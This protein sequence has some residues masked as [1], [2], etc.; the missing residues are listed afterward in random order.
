MGITRFLQDK[1]SHF[2]R[3]AKKKESIRQ[4]LRAPEQSNNGVVNVHRYDPTNIGD[5]YCAPHHYFDQLKGTELD[6]F[7]YKREDDI[8]RR[9]WSQKIIDNSLIIGGG[10]LLN[11]EG[12]YMQMDLFE[13]L[14]TK[15]KKTVIWGAGHNSKYRRDF[16]KLP[17]YS[18][19]LS[20][21]GLVGTRDYGMSD[22]WVPCVSCMH[23]IFDKT[24]DVKNETGI[25]FHKKTLRDQAVINKFAS[26]PSTSNDSDFNEVV[27]FIGET[28]TILTDSYHAMYW[29]L[30]LG[31]KVMVFPNSS[32][33]Y[34]FKYMPV[35]S[36]FDRFEQDLK[37]VHAYSGVMEECREINTKFAHKVFDYLNI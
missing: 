37:K 6:I 12:F 17:S 23:P 20:K 30:M 26:F 24:Y 5:F 13:Q 35:I 19:D 22:N 27:K 8:V 28:D 15:G 10:G 2:G 25:I 4:V 7:D 34:N 33:F 1:L 9:N 36:S 3:S 21:F 11:R 31:K 32:K 29:S 16:G 14:G 18:V